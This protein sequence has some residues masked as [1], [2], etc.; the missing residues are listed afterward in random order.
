ML[1]RVGV[2]RFLMGMGLL[3]SGCGSSAV[4]TSSSAGSGISGTKMHHSRT[5][6][7]SGRLVAACL[8][9]P[10]VTPSRTPRRITGAQSAALRIMPRVAALQ[11]LLVSPVAL[12]VRATTGLRVHLTAIGQLIQRALGHPAR[13]SAKDL[14]RAEV[15]FTAAAQRDRIPQCGLPS[16]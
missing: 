9:M 10:P 6:S 8:Q 14:V 2:V 3:L 12:R 5:R 16:S 15:A 4:A 1:F 13:T 11:H 7:A